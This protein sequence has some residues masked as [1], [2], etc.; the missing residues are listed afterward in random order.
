MKGKNSKGGYYVHAGASGNAKEE[1][2]D[3]ETCPHPEGHISR[4]GTN[5]YK[6][7]IRCSKC[8]KLLVDRDTEW[9]AKEKKEREEFKSSG[10]KLR[11]ASSSSSK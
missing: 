10:R 7:K 6:D 3:P 5:Q 8:D 1:K 9:W 2:L 4:R 11:P